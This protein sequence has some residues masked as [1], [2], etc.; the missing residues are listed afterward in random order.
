M[1]KAALIATAT[2]GA[3][4]L[5]ASAQTVT[6][7]PG[8][9][10]DVAGLGNHV[11]TG[12][13]MAGMQVTYTTFSGFTETL[14]WGAL[15]GGY[16]GQCGVM[17]SDG[18]YR[19]VLRFTCQEDT[20][21]SYAGYTWLLSYAG[22]DQ[23]TGEQ[24]HGELSTV[25]LNGASSRTVFDCAWTGNS[26]QQNGNTATEVGTSGSDKG[27][28]AQNAGFGNEPTFTYSNIV[29]IGGIAPVGDIYEQLLID[30]T[31]RNFGANGST[32]YVFYVDT[33]H[34]DPNSPIPSPWTSTPPTTVP[35]PS[36]YALMAS[37]LAAI[38]GIARR[39]RTA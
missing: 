12:A 20:Y 3:I 25:V 7:T 33:D 16:A 39:R 15:G 23:F 5:P 34:T 10:Y 29:G 30:F 32:A 4:A 37:G 31:G 35:E 18:G 21:S 8:T 11:A 28:S 17:S 19:F 9:Q 38:F 26:C 13:S 1:S 14:T 27:W 22:K 2:L 24:L 36:T 6:Y